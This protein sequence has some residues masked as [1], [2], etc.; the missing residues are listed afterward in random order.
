MRDSMLVAAV[1]LVLGAIVGQAGA[2]VEVVFEQASRTAEGDTT[3]GYYSSILW[4]ELLYDDASLDEHTNLHAVESWGY[5]F[6][7]DF[8]ISV[9][10][11]ADNAGEIGAM[12]AQRTFLP[13]EFAVAPTG[14]HVFSGHF[15]W[16][17]ELATFEL[18]PPMRMDGG[19]SYWIGIM[20]QTELGW[21]YDA[22]SGNDRIMYSNADGTDF[23]DQNDT[24][25]AFRLLG[26]VAPPADLAEPYGTLDFTDVV[27]FLGAFSLGG[28]AADL[29][30]PTGVLDYSDVVAFLTSFG[31]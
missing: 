6:E 24:D 22:L 31:G 16:N 7:I 29:A 3:N 25:M 9:S 18:D 27:A 14:G 12:V 8:E 4:N 30:P 28:S 11:Y 5:G 1:G 20:G 23:W 21:S 26:E 13:G 2:Q 15:E 10:L 17:E 19:Q